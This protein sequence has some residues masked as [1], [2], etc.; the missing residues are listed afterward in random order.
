MSQEVV[1]YR[2]HPSFTELVPRVKE[3]VELKGMDWAVAALVH[4]SV[5]YHTYD[6]SAKNLLESVLKGRNWFVRGL[7][8]VLR[9]M[10]LKRL[11]MTSNVS[12]ILRETTQNTLE[13]LSKS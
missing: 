9:V 13:G 5:G 10:R 8:L 1:E 2:E 3:Y 7:W 4:G 11:Y 6:R 12:S